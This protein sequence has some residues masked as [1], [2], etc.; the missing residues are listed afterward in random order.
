MTIVVARRFGDRI[1]IMSDTMISDETGVRSNIIP[2][3]LKSII[4][5]KWLT[6]SYAG[7]F[8]QAIDSIRNIYRNKDI[9]TTF[10]VNQLKKTTLEYEGEIEFIIC[11]HEPDTRLIK[12]SNGEKFEGANTYWI[13]SNEA[14]SD[15]SKFNPPNTHTNDSLPEF[16]SPE[17]DIFKYNFRSF[18][19]ET[20]CSGVG[21]VVIDCLCSSFG[22][23]Y[24]GYGEAYSWDT[25]HLGD[26]YRWEKQQE[27]NMTGMYHSECNISSATERGIAIVGLYLGQA[28]IGFIYDPIHY[29][30]AMRIENMDHSSF[31]ELVWNAGT[32]LNRSRKN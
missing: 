7:L 11:S 26:N 32:I 20:R 2:G 13:G 8:V 29:D 5:N 19:K 15:F 9:T 25:I 1:S 24:P 17:E 3:Q 27:I 12:I 28:K 10:A 30:K 22:H 6:I 16:V 4:I 14:A 18:I 31:S 23:G 21:G